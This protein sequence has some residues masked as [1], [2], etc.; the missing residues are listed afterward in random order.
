MMKLEPAQL[1]N[2]QVEQVKQLETELDT[3][4]LAV[5][6]PM[7]FAQLTESQ[8]RELQKTEEALGCVVL[9]YAQ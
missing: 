8:I 5:E 6:E 4:L 1:S 9:A 7:R 2:D 3:L